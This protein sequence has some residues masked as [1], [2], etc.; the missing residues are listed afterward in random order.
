[1]KNLNFWLA[2]LVIT[3]MVPLPLSAQ[4]TDEKQDQPAKSTVTTNDSRHSFALRNTGVLFLSVEFTTALLLGF[5]GPDFVVQP[6]ADNL[7][8]ADAWCDT[9][10]FDVAISEALLASNPHAAATASHVFT[11][12]LTPTFVFGGAIFGSTIADNWTYALQD[13]VIMLN[14]FSLS[15]GFNSI[16]KVGAK[17]QRPAY[18][19]GREK[20]T[21]GSPKE[22]FVSFY[23]GDTTWAFTLAASGTTLAYLRGY[24]FAPYVAAISGGLA[25]IGGTLRISGDMHWATDVLSGAVVGVIVGAGLPLLLHQRYS[26][27][28]TVSVIPVIGHDKLGL[29]FR[30]DW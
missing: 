14:A 12:V 27:M 1:M 4:T 13:I 2:I 10:D 28:N 21:E 3:L 19:Y 25:L 6:Q 26:G 17:R 20:H 8:C 15:T 22:E 24:W 16:A 5:A 30:R 29:A 23:S 11:I 18:H 7:T 9:N